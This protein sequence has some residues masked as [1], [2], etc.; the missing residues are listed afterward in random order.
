MKIFSKEGYDGARCDQCK[1]GYF[2]YPNCTSCDCDARGS[3][4]TTC[5]STGKCRCLPNYGGLKCSD[6]SVGHYGYPECLPCNCDPSGSH[7]LS[8]D[9]Q[10]KCICKRNFD[11]EKCSTCREGFYNYPACEE[12]NCDPAGVIVAFEGCGSVAA[13]ELCK[14]KDR[15]TGRI[16][17]QCKDLFWNLQPSNP[18]GCEDCRCKREGTVSAVGNCDGKTGQCICKENVESRNCEKCRDGSFG[19][20][21]GNLFGCTDCACDIGGALPETTC[22]P[23]T[24]ACVCRSFITGRKCDEPMTTYYYPTLY[25]HQLEVENGQTSSGAPAR[26]G[27]DETKFPRYSWKGYA[28]FTDLMKEVIMDFNITRRGSF[29]RT[30][31]SYLNEG[32][33]PVPG[34]LTLTRVSAPGSSAALDDDEPQVVNINF[35]PTGKAN[36]KTDFASTKFGQ[37]TTLYLEPGKW[38]ASLK[39]EKRLEVDYIVLLPEAYYEANILQEPRSVPCRYRPDPL[40]LCELYSYPNFPESSTSTKGSTGYSDDQRVET[41]KYEDIDL[42]RKQKSETTAVMDPKKPQIRLDMNRVKRGKNVMVIQYHNTPDDSGLP[43]EATKVVAEVSSSGNLKASGEAVLSDCPYSWFCRVAVTSD[44]GEV[45]PFDFDTDDGQIKISAQSLPDNSTLAIDSI[46]AIPANEWSLD[47]VTPVFKCIIKDKQCVPSSYPPLPAG[48]KIEIEKDQS[49]NRILSLSTPPVND[50]LRLKAEPPQVVWLNSSGP[51]VEFR[52]NVPRSERYLLLHY[53]QSESPGFDLDVTI[54]HGSSNDHYSSAVQVDYCPT[55]AGCRAFIKQ[56]DSNSS[57]FFLEDDFE[58]TITTPNGTNILLDYVLAIPIDDIK[59]GERSQYDKLMKLAPQE[60]ALDFIKNCGA[61]NAFNMNPNTASD[62]CKKAAFSLTMDYNQ[63]A[64]RCECNIKGST[65]YECEKFGGQCSCKANVIGRRCDECK[66]GYYGFPNCKPCDCPSTAYCHPTSGKCICPPRVTGELCDSCMPFTFGYD[67]MLGCEECNCHRMGVLKNKTTGKADLQCDLITGQCPCRSNIDGRSCDKCLAGFYFFPHCQLCDCDIRGVTEDICSQTDGQCYCKEYTTGSYCDECSPDSFNLEYSNPKGCTKCFCFGTTDRCRSSVLRTTQ[68]MQMSDKDWKLVTIRLSDQS[69][70]VRSLATGAYD[71]NQNDV[72]VEARLTV[73]FAAATGSQIT[74]TVSNLYYSAPKSYLNKRITSYGGN[75]SYAISNSVSASNRDGAPSAF[76]LILVGSNFTIGYSQDEQPLSTDEPFEYNFTLIERK[77]RH[78]TRNPVTREQIMMVLL[79][80]EAIYVRAS[81]FQPTVKVSLINMKMDSAVEGNIEGAP[82]AKRVEQCYCPRNYKGTSCEECNDGYYRAKAGP[83]LGFCIPCQC[84]GHSE[85][86]DVETG[87]C[88]NCTHNTHGDF[89]EFCDGGYYGDATKGTQFD[90]MICPCPR[91]DVS[92]N[93]ATSCEVSPDGTSVACNCKEGYVPPRCD[94][95]AAG[96]FG[97]PYELGDTCKPCNCNNNIDPSN[98]EACDSQTGICTTCLNNTFGPACEICAPGFYGD[99]V[100][101]KDCKT[102]S[103]DPVGT[104]RCDH[105]TGQCICKPNVEGELCDRCA[106][107]H[108]GLDT[109]SSAPFDGCVPCECAEASF[110][111]ACNPLTGQCQCQEGVYGRTCDRCEPGWWQYSVNGCTS[112]NCGIKYSKDG[113]VC[114]QETGQCEC[115]PGVIGEK[116]DSCPY[117][118]VFVEKTGCFECEACTHFLLDDTDE[119]RNMIDPL[120]R[121]LQD[122]SISVFAYRRLNNVN[123]SIDDYRVALENQK[124]NPRQINTAEPSSR[125]KDVENYAGAMESNSSAIAK[126][127]VTINEDCNVVRLAAMESTD[128]VKEAISASTNLLLKLNTLQTSFENPSL[129]QDMDRKITETEQILDYLKQAIDLE[130]ILSNTTLERDEAEKFREVVDLFSLPSL[131]TANRLQE[132]QTAIDLMRER[133]TELL[134]KSSDSMAKA[135]QAEQL[136][137]MARE[138]KSITESDIIRAAEGLSV[139]NSSVA[140]AKQK[141]EESR[142]SLTQYLSHLTDMNLSARK[143]KEQK[144]AMKERVDQKRSEPSQ[145]QELVNQMK[146]KAY[147]LNQQ[148]RELEQQFK[149]TRTSSV[150]AV[151]AANAYSNIMS[152][153]QS[154]SESA[155]AAAQSV[156]GLQERRNATKENV[157][158]SHDESDRLLKTSQELEA[159]IE[160]ELTA[161]LNRNMVEIDG[162]DQSHKS[163]DENHERIARELD[164]LKKNELASGS[165]AA[166][167]IATENVEKAQ[168]VSKQV[169]LIESDIDEK[170]KEAANIPNLFQTISNDIQ[171]AHSYA[172]R[173]SST[174]PELNNL[175]DKVDRKLP[176]IEKLRED[177]TGTV[178]ELRKRIA[179]ARGLAN[180]IE[181]GVQLYENTTI[182]LRNPDS[183]MTSGTYSKFGLS[184]KTQSYNAILAYIGN[185]IAV[186]PDRKRRSIDGGTISDDPLSATSSSFDFMALEIRNGQILLT[187]DLGSGPERIENGISVSDDLWHDVIV[188]RIGNLVRLTVSGQQQESTEKNLEG[189]HHV[190]NLDPS[191][192]KVFVGSVPE[193]ITI[194]DVV[195]QSKFTGAI[196]NVAFG[197]TPLGLWNF[198]QASENKQGILP[199]S[200]SID[201][202]ITAGGLR[203]DGNSYVILSKDKFNFEKETFLQLS[204]KTFA[205]EGLIFIIGNEGSDYFAVY[206]SDAKLSLIYDLG[207]GYTVLSTKDGTVIN[208]GNWH[209]L[210]VSRDEKYAILKFDS[211]EVEAKEAIGLQSTLDTNDNIYFGGYAGPHPYR[212][213]TNSGFEGCIRDVQLGSRKLDLS[214]NKE[215][216]ANVAKGCP[217]TVSREASFVNISDSGFIEMPLKKDINPS[218]IIMLKYRT[219]ERNGLLFYTANPDHTSFLTL[220]LSDGHLVLRLRTSATDENPL[221]EDQVVRTARTY[222]GDSWHYVTATKE[223]TTLRLEV[224]DAID[225][226]AEKKELSQHLSIYDPDRTVNVYFGSMPR[227]T[228]YI[229]SQNSIPNGFVGCFG[230]VTINGNL[231]N[232]ANSPNR[233]KASLTSCHLTASSEATNMI[234][235]PSVGEGS[236]LFPQ[237]TTEEVTEPSITLEGCGLP[238][239]PVKDNSAQPEDGIRVG[240]SLD[241][242]HEFYVQ[243]SMSASLNDDSRFSIEFRATESNGI[244]MYLTDLKNIDFVALTMSDGQINYMWNC[245][246]GV[247]I[248]KS[249]NT[250]ND[251][252]WHKVMFSRNLKDGVLTIDE[253]EVGKNSSSGPGTSLNIR[254]PIFVGGIS[255]EMNKAARNNLRE[256]TSSFPGCLRNLYVQGIPLV[257]TRDSIPHNSQSC[258]SQI[259]PGMF[260]H[261]NGKAFVN[262]KDAFRVG[263]R[264]KIELKIKPRTM[265]GV[266]MSVHG[267]RGSNTLGKDFLIL[268]MVNGKIKF[269]VD[270]GA[271]VINVESSVPQGTLCDGKWHS[272]QAV[273]EKNLVTLSV[274]SGDHVLAMGVGGVS[275]TD[276]NDPLYVGGIPEDDSTSIGLSTREQFVGCI[277]DI[278]ISD[279]VLPLSA[280]TFNGQ[281]TLNTCP[282]T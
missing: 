164:Q 261:S 134:N 102:C 222:V 167:A 198:A 146:V 32:D 115:L 199:K 248:V 84:N 103:C 237:V 168:M 92:N 211:E 79:N 93:F 267:S 51:V 1:S 98:P 110:S 270:N 81:Y 189:S 42:G 119:L 225:D 281:I 65:S 69:I 64:L 19:L 142:S 40:T 268:E 24:G 14:C 90:C 171:T 117:R 87:K 75:I 260:F 271:G 231:Q 209:A 200:G 83:Y 155:Q 154:A 111:S 136:S 214:S 279:R 122:A 47:H 50:P 208:D 130:E 156:I 166:I 202:S 176:R 78:L 173:V 145:L 175:T 74:T 23:F 94:Y 278:A 48:S 123:K 101:K 256:I 82:I 157:L 12:C 282:T 49:E 242:R 169:N 140:E 53:I 131:R 6:C 108:Y 121:D 33:E 113:T 217:A 213:F 191:R 55:L 63:K 91:P 195:T 132:T 22:D 224:D 124:R 185:P 197:D 66:T 128:V 220:Y 116:C 258:G 125:L 253:I 37:I 144:E 246:G 196:A 249:E 201:P 232:F 27:Y 100:S 4:A 105:A 61:S 174:V 151:S 205:R 112:C 273:K 129:I 60:K 192:S 272:I 162:I 29:F 34:S 10:G 25:Q 219:T 8:C 160:Q 179:L 206:M 95:C 228:V 188:E 89:C 139:V 118:W 56:R 227:D 159:K 234:P 178:D 57:V 239:V 165:N 210:E 70:D 9:S 212:E 257:F 238:V 17:N 230:D 170:A 99:A 266:I 235:N 13:G 264:I 76:D 127:T 73:P 44:A 135:V 86:C 269:A 20:M 126:R 158:T 85:Q 107:D 182:Q 277:K 120:S 72:A 114:N 207:S 109:S 147:G 104:E 5:S 137:I 30:I 58:V 138:S 184:F 52:G 77:F 97:R 240:N 216:S 243:P 38:K 265:E 36:P 218:A 45:I 187:I 88:F 226:V 96:Y 54:T 143:L 148:S 152:E 15:V 245:G 26:F 106:P 274:D 215:A 153:T 43:N 251:G 41:K 236:T 67:A 181:L 275:S 233:P 31:I 252:Q 59:L 161:T 46:T 16:C 28:T 194:Q 247:G 190:F 68:I 172:E 254:N 150:D 180:R 35:E 255:Y 71:L 221:G 280:A 177:L 11:G 39:A 250:Y 244:I 141:L 163:N 186:T 204:F 259:E 62:Y 3:S 149:A 241:S 80:L 183:L 263:E 223:V 133:F 21:E 2:G 7:G 262:L 193:G 276:T 18:L 203:F 229:L